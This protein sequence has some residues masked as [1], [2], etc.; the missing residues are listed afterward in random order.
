MQCKVS[1]WENVHCMISTL[2]VADII[3]LGIRV[4]SAKNKYGNDADMVVV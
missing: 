3:G 2:P 1:K 4:K